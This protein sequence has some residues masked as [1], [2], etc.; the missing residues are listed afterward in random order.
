[1]AT[2]QAVNP[3]APIQKIIA[4]AATEVVFFSVAKQTVVELAADQVLY[5]LEDFIAIFAIAVTAY[6]AQIHVDPIAFG[7]QLI[8]HGVAASAPQIRMVA[9]A[10]IFQNIVAVAAVQGITAATANQHIVT[11]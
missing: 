9:T 10:R 8:A 11:R 7:D 6:L 1:M 2:R 4:I 3:F 5:Q